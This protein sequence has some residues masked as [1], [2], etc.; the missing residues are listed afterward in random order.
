MYPKTEITLSVAEG[1]K[2]LKNTCAFD[3]HFPLF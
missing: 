1:K 3:S 2:Y